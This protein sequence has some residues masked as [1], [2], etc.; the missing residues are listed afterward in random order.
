MI[1]KEKEMLKKKWK[2]HSTKNDKKKENKNE[3]KY[4]HILAFWHFLESQIWPI[5]PFVSPKYCQ[6]LIFYLCDGQY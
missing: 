2:A 4:W 6:K 5:F 3:K 1:K